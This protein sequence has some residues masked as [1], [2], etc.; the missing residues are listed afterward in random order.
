M[1]ERGMGRAVPPRAVWL[2]AEWPRTVLPATVLP[3]TGLL[4]AGLLTAVL[5]GTVLLATVLPWGGLGG[6]V[7]VSASCSDCEL[8]PTL[9]IQ[10]PAKVS[11][12]A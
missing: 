5:P 4:T 1:R 12:S 6:A 3:A 10:A 9:G 8:V 2:G 7:H 11:R